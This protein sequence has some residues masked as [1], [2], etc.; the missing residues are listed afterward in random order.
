AA[1]LVV[2]ALAVGGIGGYTVTRNLESGT[3][4][5]SASSASVV[6]TPPSGSGATSAMKQLTLSEIEAAVDPA[7]VDITA[8]LGGSG[9]AAGTGMVISSTGEVLTNNH[10]ITGA[11]SIMVQIGGTG[12]K[13]A[14]QVVGYDTTDDVAVLQIAHVSGLATIATA[15]AS[16]VSAN[17]AVVAIGNALGKAGTPT[18]VDGVVAALAQ[19]ITA[20]DQYGASAETLNGLIEFTADVQPG[21][22][23]GSLV[24]AYG[25]VVGMTTAASSNV[26]SRATPAS[27]STTAYAIPIDRALAI[28]RQIGAGS[29]SATVH[30]GEHGLLGIQVDATIGGGVA[31][32]AVQSGS[33]A[34]QA[35]IG[36]G[37]I[38]TAV[39]GK[40]IDSGTALSTALASTHVGEKIAVSWQDGNGAPHTAST[41]L[42]TGAA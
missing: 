10:V 34:A 25:Q 23:G 38:I 18:A 26:R 39:N 42:T 3:S 2:A 19:T 1:A 22:S 28:A 17:D 9:T 20:S 33:A 35:G 37:D 29:E 36:A 21:D 8:T 27:T 40:N 16:T 14:A 32:V 15:S 5:V 12:A 6:T 30:I 4:T 41:T 11:T 24:N 7:L 31:V 13:Y